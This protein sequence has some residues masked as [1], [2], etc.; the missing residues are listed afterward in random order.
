M[1]K[2]RLLVAIPC[3]RA[4]A[5]YDRFSVWC[6]NTGGAQTPV[7]T[8]DDTSTP[9]FQRENTRTCLEPPP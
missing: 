4:P 3:L 6:L 1:D 8:V 5:K 9:Y 2:F 7:Y